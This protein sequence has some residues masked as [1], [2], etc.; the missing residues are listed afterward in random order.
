MSD[1]SS[2]KQSGSRKR[3]YAAPQLTY[4]GVVRQLTMSGSGQTVEGIDMMTGL[5]KTQ[6]NALP[7]A[8]DRSIKEEMVRIGY[9]SSGIGLYLFRFKKEYRN[10]LGHERQFGVMADEV[11]TVLPEAVRVHPDGYKM[12]DYSMLG[13]TRFVH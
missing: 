7:C 11:E 13:I 9:H 6:S 4:Y 10:K 1:K 2:A 3:P 5:C 8:S 12:V